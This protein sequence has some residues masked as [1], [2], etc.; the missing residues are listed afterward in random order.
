[1]ITQRKVIYICSNFYQYT[2][3][4]LDEL[5]KQNYIVHYYD[6]RGSNNFFYKFLV[7]Y[8]RVFRDFLS[9]VYLKKIVKKER[10]FNPDI[11]VMTNPLFFSFQNI[12]F[13]LKSF[14]RSEKR[15]HLWDS[16]AN[17][18]Y[19]KECLPLFDKVFSFDKND[20]LNYKMTYQPDFY[21]S[22][23]KEKIEYFQF[24]GSTPKKSI[25]I[26]FV[27][28]ATP[29]RIEY[30]KKIKNKNP[31]LIFSFFLFIR[32]KSLYFFSKFFTKKYR[33][34]KVSDFSFSVLSTNE[35]N[36][37]LL[38]SYGVL[39]VFYGYQ[40]GLTTRTIEALLLGVKL[41]TSNESI[42][43][44][45]L[46]NKDNVL[47]LP[48]GSGCLIPTSFLRSSPVK[49]DSKIIEEYSV[50]SFVNNIFGKQI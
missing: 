25:D 14:P 11:I 6:V 39:D 44:Y 5:E 8:F 27:G 29:E 45:D 33:D 46:F 17:Y 4:I 2:S 34:C 10:N 41:I 18:P 26:S 42:K 37:I 21:D 49:Y 3:E 9:H 38:S 22:S 50:E 30:I 23:L 20:C 16:L 19:L 12:M 1:M 36:R 40:R 31:S 43:E 35:K 28:S 13:F 7:K 32:Y 47:I 48:K 15:L 24:G